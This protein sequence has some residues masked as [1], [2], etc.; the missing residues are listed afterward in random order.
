MK[1]IYNLN[2]IIQIY[3]VKG[4]KKMENTILLFSYHFYL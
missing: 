2:T 1:I 4:N 3:R